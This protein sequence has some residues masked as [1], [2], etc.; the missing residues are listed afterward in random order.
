[1]LH[2][3]LPLNER[4]LFAETAAGTL[5]ER[6]KIETNYT[7]NLNDIYKSEE[8]WENEFKWV[9][10]KIPEYKNFRGKIGK[11][12][13]DL[14]DI[15]KF[16]D[17]LGIKLERLY[18]YAMLSKDLDLANSNSRARYDR[19]ASLFANASAN[20]SFIRPE[21]LEIPREKIEV[22]LNELDE[23]KVYK[24]SIENLF[25]T[26]EHTL[27]KE[28]EELLAL[29]SE[30]NHIPYNTFSV[31]TDAEMQFPFVKDAEGKDVQISH[32]RYTAALY[33][34]DR[35]YRQRVYK[36]FYKPF[37]DYKNTL[38]TL[39]NGVIKTH[40]YI[41]RARK[42]NSSREAALDAGNIPV[43]VYDNLVKT[44]NENL[45]PLHRW[46]KV[47]KKV[48]G[49]DELHP[50][51]AYVTLFPSVKK[52]YDFETAKN[53][54]LESLTPFGPEYM[55]NIKKAFDERWI[56][57]YETKGKRS[58][59]YSSG[60]TF[61]VHPYVLLNWNNQLN[62]VFTL[63]H[64]MGHNMHSFYTGLNQP[65]TY[66]NYSIFVAEVASTA[67]EALLLDYLIEHAETKEEKLALIE[68]Y[69]TSIT[70]TFY[71]QTCFAE[72]E[73]LVHD[74]MENGEALTPDNLSPLYRELTQRYWGPDMVVDDE[75]DYTWARVPHFYYDFYVYQYATGLAASQALTAGI[76]EEGKPAIDRYLNYL[77]SGSSDYP[78]N[79]L[80]KAGVD[81]NTPGPVLKTIAKMNEL[82]DRMEGLI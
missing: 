69:L 2:E 59:A 52:E 19:V 60:T 75:E 37:M 51:D 45:T 67:N 33:S 7:W 30:I 78:I 5:P 77:K 41:T 76:K 58:G 3:N 21:I 74:K 40:I 44:V 56:D 12:A 35:G 9:G 10:E 29:S 26:K 73:Q 36:G 68:K 24:H 18:L 32:G 34:T 16:D 54:V 28:Q 79:I 13:G 4:L 11:S 57:V 61:G 63:A 22:F 20:S 25:R 71:R 82:L 1:M 65:Y 23:L 66:A 31:F 8:D 15:F 48:L 47:R 39:F 6:D 55:G 62:D 27:T 72:F 81:M 50:Y 53:I 49:L 80:K 70:S 46:A 64:E 42:Y 43:S 17:E 38:A 14:L